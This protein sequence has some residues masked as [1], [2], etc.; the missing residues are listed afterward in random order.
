[1]PSELLQTKTHP[2]VYLW[3][4]QCLGTSHK[5]I[6]PQKI[7][8][9]ENFYAFL[10]EEPHRNDLFLSLS[11]IV[12]CARGDGLDHRQVFIAPLSNVKALLR[13]C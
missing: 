8:L 4:P 5:I 1:M 2:N 13:K 6:F 7:S 11:L 3:P 9:A 10:K 12:F